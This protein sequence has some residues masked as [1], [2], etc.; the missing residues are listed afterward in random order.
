MRRFL[1]LTAFLLTLTLLPIQAQEKTVILGGDTIAITVNYE[2]VY[3]SGMYDFEVNGETLSAAKEGTIQVG[4]RIIESN[5][6]QVSSLEE[7]FANLKMLQKERNQVPVTVIRNGQREAASLFVCYLASEKV[8]KTGLYVKDKIK[9]VGTMT[10]YDPATQT[11][12][13]LGH[14][15]A[16]EG[17]S[18]PADVTMGQIFEA[19]VVS[20][21]RS[22]SGNPGEKI[23]QS[24]S[25]IPIGTVSK[26][27]IY[28]LYGKVQTYPSTSISVPVASREEATV[29]PAEIYTVVQGTIPQR[30]S[31]QITE[32]RKQN[33]QAVKGIR[34]QVTDPA[35][36][37][38]TGGII[39]GMSGSPILQNGKLIGAVTH[40]VTSQPE[41]GYGIY[42]DWMLQ[43]AQSE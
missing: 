27:T 16:E 35:L 14:E 22:S 34:F 17:Q 6:R 9:G 18:R 29:G 4:D 8:F 10:Y 38:Q 30:Y 33:G 36:L 11:F 37:N 21:R 5:G 25:L 15:I 28:G 41:S 24:D 39:Q 32:V 1:G 19:T 26:N 13:A 2:G 43:E 20:V 40:M 42:I 3:V 31:I 12:A 23:C 7:L